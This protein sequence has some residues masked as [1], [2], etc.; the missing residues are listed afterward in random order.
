MLRQLLPALL[1]CAALSVP[2]AAP[3]ATV[4]PAHHVFVIVL[5]N[6]EFFDTFGPGGQAFAP[7]LNGTLVPQGQLLTQYYGVGH[8]TA[9]NYIAMASGQPPTPSGQDDCPDDPSNGAADPYGGTQTPKRGP[10]A[11]QWPYNIATGDGCMY[12]DNFLTIGAQL[13]NARYTWK[14]YIEDM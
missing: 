13:T 3:A 5:E 14:S 11:D 9:D 2:T 10:R 1:A 6:H 4:P 8:S 12:P 7:Y